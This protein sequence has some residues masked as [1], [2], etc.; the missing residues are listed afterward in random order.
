MNVKY[1]RHG[2]RKWEDAICIGQPTRNTWALLRWDC[3]DFTVVIAP[4][5]RV[6]FA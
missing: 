4:A 3:E 6:R 5:E 1:R 2:Q